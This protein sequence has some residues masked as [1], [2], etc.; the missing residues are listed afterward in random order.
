VGLYAV[1]MVLTFA[2]L[3]GD[4]RCY[5]IGFKTF[6]ETVL[7]NPLFMILY[8]PIATQAIFTRELDWVPIE[9]QAVNL[10]APIISDEEDEIKNIAKK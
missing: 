4:R 8:V 5:K 3:I 10:E 7:L 6:C 9:R 2:I 1:L